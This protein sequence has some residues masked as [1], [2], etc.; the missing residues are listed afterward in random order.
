MTS[1]YSAYAKASAKAPTGRRLEGEAFARAAALLD[2]AA[3]APDDAAALAEALKFNTMLWTIVQ[4][5]LTEPSDALTDALR[6]DLASLS[7]FMDKRA[8]RLLQGHDRESLEAM[9]EVN[10]NIA[11]G[12]L[13]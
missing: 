4:A 12:L 5:E 7:L 3:R 6:A 10:R 9:V 1:G 11:S 8:A 2:A 13:R